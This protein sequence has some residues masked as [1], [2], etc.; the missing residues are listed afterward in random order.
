[1]YGIGVRKQCSISLEDSV[2]F[3]FWFFGLFFVN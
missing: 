3:G 1:M 2:S